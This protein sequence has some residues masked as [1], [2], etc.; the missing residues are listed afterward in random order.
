[1]VDS[2]LEHSHNDRG[3]SIVLNRTKTLSALTAATLAVGLSIGAAAQATSP[4][5]SAKTS[6]VA[7]V[8]REE[9]VAKRALVATGSSPEAVTTVSLRGD[10]VGTASWSAYRYTYK[11]TLRDNSG[12]LDVKWSSSCP[13]SFGPPRTARCGTPGR[14]PASGG[15]CRTTAKLT[16][17]TMR[18]RT[19]LVVPSRYGSVA[20]ASGAVSTTATDVGGLE[21]LLS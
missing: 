21:P 19:V 10:G 14:T 2:C 20:A 3:G 8:D 1:M 7:A 6:G 16:T 17:L 12:I 11:G 5:T 15:R 18:R 4:P 13:E 9:Q